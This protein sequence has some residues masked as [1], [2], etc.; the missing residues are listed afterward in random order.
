MKLET[1]KIEEYLEKWEFKA[2]YLLCSSD[3]E[4]IYMHELLES[5]DNECKKLWHDL[6]LSYTQVKGLPLLRD[7]VSRQYPDFTGDNILMFAGAEEGI[8]CAMA[9]LLTKKDH[10]ITLVP[11]YQSLKSIPEGLGIQTTI[12]ELKEKHH[13]DLDL[14]AVK[15]AIKKNTKMII[16]NYP[17]NPTGAIIS[18][19]K[20]KQLIEIARKH[21]IYIFS[22]EVYR[23]GEIDMQDRLDPMASIYEKGIS[24]GVMSKSFGMPALRIGWIAIQDTKILHEIEKIKYYT[25]IANSAPSE[26]L[27]LMALRKIDHVVDRNITITR[28]NLSI[29][30]RFFQ[31]HKD[32]LS[33]V[34][35]KGGCVGFPNLLLKT[36]IEKFAEKLIEK[37][38]V[39]ILPGTIFDNNH[40][41]FR[42]GFGRNNMPESLE[43]L[44]R[45]LKSYE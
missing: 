38:G 22:D 18:H 23:M 15:S 21:N 6:R 7:E 19:E 2:P 44:E 12:I 40:N 13:W 17:H 4:S 41:H 30:D 37:E 32:T 42:I 39:L 31:N 5:T 43:R 27:A 24:L 29:L 16:I 8:F 25:S 1:F 36:P 26:L 20:Q 14:D 45:F 28:K 10:V 11:C 9:A 3:S 35:P 34:R 33:W